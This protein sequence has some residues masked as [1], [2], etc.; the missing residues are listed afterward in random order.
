VCYR[1]GMKKILFCLVV[2][3]LSACSVSNREMCETWARK[4]ELAGL[5]SDCVACADTLGT[6]DIHL[7]R[8]CTFRRGVDSVLAR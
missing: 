3:V 2:S 5:V 6:S 1:P 8:S 4:G 7:V